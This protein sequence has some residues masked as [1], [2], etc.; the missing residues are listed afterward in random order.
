[1][2][3]NLTFYGKR[4][5]DIILIQYHVQKHDNFSKALVLQVAM[6]YGS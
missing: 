5:L 1:M 3:I 6:P 4:Q 2:M